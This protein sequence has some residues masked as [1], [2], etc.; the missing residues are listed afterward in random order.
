MLKKSLKNQKIDR[1]SSPRQRLEAMVNVAT[2]DVHEIERS[3][4]YSLTGLF[5]KCNFPEKYQLNDQV[6]I[7]F[8]DENGVPHSHTGEVV[9]KS[10]DGVGIHYLKKKTDK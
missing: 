6:D 7:T 1:R 3:M 4:N 5:L 9:R 2:K 10:R 8:K